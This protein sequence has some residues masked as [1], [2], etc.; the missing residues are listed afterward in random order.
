[1]T[2]SVVD[3]LAHLWMEAGKKVC[4]IRL[5]DLAEYFDCKMYPFGPLL[6]IWSDSDK[7]ST[8]LSLIAKLNLIWQ[9]GR[10][11]NSVM[12]FC[13]N[14]Y[15]QCG[16]WEKQWFFLMP[17]QQ[18][19]STGVEEWTCWNALLSSGGTLPMS[20]C[21]SNNEIF[22]IREFSIFESAP[23]HYK[24]AVFVISSPVSG[25]VEETLKAII[26]ASSLHYCVVVTTCHP[27]V[28]R[29]S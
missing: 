29:C 23:A 24:K 27:A 1:M 13:F 8:S 17:K 16:R 6:P 12:N 2:G 26:S 28:T 14:L 18:N 22:S 20:I 19:V 3:V 11:L 7:A 10:G 4:G 5:S 25:P 21:Y 9:C 15:L